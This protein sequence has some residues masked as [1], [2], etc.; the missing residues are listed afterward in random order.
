MVVK[1]NVDIQ[2]VG[3]LQK[4]FHVREQIGVDL[5]SRTAG[6]FSPIRVNDEVVQRNLIG[7]MIILNLLQSLFVGVGIV[8]AIPSAKRRK[9]KHFGLARQLVEILAQLYAVALRE[10]NI[11]IRCIVALIKA[12]CFPILA[13]VFRLW[14]EAPLRHGHAGAISHFP[15]QN[16]LAWVG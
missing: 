14:C 6:S 15:S 1:H 13:V 16:V 10:K 4:T 11:H 3:V 9:R 12:I 8:T 5:I 7:L 2:V